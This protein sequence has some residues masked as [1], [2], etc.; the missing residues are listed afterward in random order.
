MRLLCLLAAFALT[1]AILRAAEIVPVEKFTQDTKLSRA[2]LSP[3]G[4]YIACLQTMEGDPWLF[5]LDLETRKSARVNPGTTRNGLRKE[6]S[7]F[8]WISDRRIS[9]GV[10]FVF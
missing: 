7:S 9:F 1:A 8:R 3:D 6:V 10:N 2:R 5:I 4:R